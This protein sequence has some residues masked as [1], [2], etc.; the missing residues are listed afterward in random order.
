[1]ARDPHTA[2]T[3]RD[4]P[5]LKPGEH[6]PRPLLKAW[7][8]GH[9]PAALKRVIASHLEACSACRRAL[10]SEVAPVRKVKDALEG[11]TLDH[12]VIERRLGEGGMGAVYRAVDARARRVVAIKVL[13]AHLSDDDS[14]ERRFRHEVDVLAK[15][16]H[17]N[18][19]AHLDSGQLPNGRGQYLVMELLE[20]ESLSERLKREVIPRGEVLGALVQACAGLEAVHRAGVLHRDLKPGNL[21]LCRDG[22][23][24]LIDFGLARSA[25]GTRLTA[26][27]LLMGTVGFVAPELLDG[28]PATVKSDLYALGIS[29]W[30]LLTRSDPFKGKNLQERIR[31]QLSLDAPKL[32]DELPDA[33]PE[34][35]AVLASVLA[36]D[37]RKRP[38]SAA[39]LGRRLGALLETPTGKQETPALADDSQPTVRVKTLSAT[40]ERLRRPPTDDSSDHK[41][42]LAPSLNHRRP[43]R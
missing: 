25:E 26:A 19:V 4:G 12:Y 40:T 38:A 2:N 37:P 34:L 27:G 6:V 29:A 7:T 36:K 13:L 33:S 10:T 24:K 31:I 35:E 14:N 42:I 3:E 41:T 5:A 15:V 8:E 11:K 23:L 30:R 22:T 20:G 18:V 1:V 28:D 21:F 9:A 32:R 17:R 39:E 43:K 16:T